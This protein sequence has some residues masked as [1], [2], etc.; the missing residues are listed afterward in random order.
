MLNKR[1]TS[2]K[3][4]EEF[5][6]FSFN[7]EQTIELSKNLFSQYFNEGLI[8]E[9]EYQSD[10]WICFY[11]VRKT[12]P[13]FDFS[14]LRNQLTFWGQDKNLYINILKSWILTQ[15]YD[16]SIESLKKYYDYIK[17]FILLSKCFKDELL[18]ECNQY[19]KYECDDRKKWNIC[20]P[21]LNFLDFYDDISSLN[22]YRQMLFD[23]KSQ[24][25][26]ESV[27]G[28]VRTLP[29]PS[30]VL[31]FSLVL[32][33]FI[34]KTEIGT[35]NYYKYFPLYI[36]WELSNIIPM[37]PSEFC[38]ISRN[39]LS[40]ENSRFYIE[41]P[42][43]KQRNNRH[44][45]QIVSTIS[46]PESIYKDLVTYKEQTDKFGESDT[47]M[48][49]NPIDIFR[50][51]QK[52]SYGFSYYHLSRLLTKFYSDVMDD[53]YNM[54]YQDYL[55]LGDTRHFAFLNLMRQGYHPIEI[56]RLGGQTSI[57]A[58]YHY[59]QHIDYWV[60]FETMKLMNNLNIN[61]TNNSGKQLTFIDEEF[62][63]D[64]VLQSNNNSF[65]KKVE[66][67]YCT[68]PYMYCKTNDCM[69]CNSWR[70]SPEEFAAKKEIITEKLYMLRNNVTKLTNTLKNLYLI[71]LNKSMKD[72]EF[73]E[74][75]ID[76]NK[77]LFYTKSEL[78]MA[79]R[80]LTNFAQ[81]IK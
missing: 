5:H 64:K 44:R 78:D 21:V 70:I 35:P 79:L 34:K 9:G 4:I 18:E 1:L 55:N 23:I 28:S 73:S 47:L 62:I 72:E 11:D 48:S 26:M 12:K 16:R 54:Q 50:E 75:S 74:V 13:I 3:E 8:L 17:D 2:D 38:D 45:I 42:R 33:D 77:D 22:N 27:S 19:L 66:L 37:R 69:E 29:I 71:A 15:L 65:H 58:Q 24:I 20:I 59:Q 25:N 6:N 81:K 76:F 43:K 61:N 36:W 41:L 49:I 39:S 7:Y 53:K 14:S 32:E 30:D 67:G 63:F 80:K 60:E 10:I 68:D 52:N 51:N 46:I 31:N 40:N 56:A 57:Q